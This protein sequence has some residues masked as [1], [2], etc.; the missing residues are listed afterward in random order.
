MSGKKC[1][2]CGSS[3]IEVDPARGDAVCTSCGTVLEDN[4]I[5]AEVEFQETAHGGAAAIGQFVSA[6]TKGGATGF[7]RAFQAGIG[8]ESREIT[9]RKARDGITALC[10]QLRLN[11]QCIDIA[12][13]FFKMALSRHLTIGRPATHTQ[14]ACVYMTCRTEGTAH[15]LID[16][17]DALQICCYQLGRAYF[18]LSRAL[19]INIPPTDP[20]LYILRFASQLQFEDKQHEVSMT[21]LRLVQRMK[22]DSIHSGRRPSGICG[23][24][25]LIAGRLHN[26]SRTPSDMVRIVKV[27][28]STIRKRLIEFGETPSSALTLDE[29]MTVDLEEEQDPPAFRAAR[30]RDKERLQKLMDEED[31]EKELTELQKEIDAQLEKDN[32][33][34][35]KMAT[36]KVITPVPALADE[37]SLEDAEATRFAAEDTLNLLGDI[38][39]DVDPKSEAASKIDKVKFEKGLGPELAVIGLGQPEEKPADKFLKPDPRPPFSADLHA[40][41]E[42]ALSAADEEYISSLIMSEDEARHKTMLWHKLNAGY[43]REQKIKEEVR[44]KE[45]EEGKKRKVRGSYKKKL[46]CNAATAGEAIEKMLAEKKISSKIN[47]D[48]LKS[49]DQPGAP[50]TPAP[51]KDTPAEDVKVATPIEVPA[52]PVPRKRKKKA[53]PATPATPKPAT[54]APATPAPATPAPATPAIPDASEDYEDDAEL[55]PADAGDEMSLAAMLQ[56]GQDDDY[57]D[58]EEY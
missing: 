7:G 17:S 52:S 34:R 35:K 37:C 45:R 49:L 41:E 14:A 22:R 42:L 24:A 13:N 12:C 36:A 27:H 54:P 18:R 53:A 43:L 21:A 6:D 4:I 56:N 47:Y 1:K 50:T 15:L 55:E 16:I 26:F 23:A 29:F 19:C 31:G 57:Y 8:Q 9:L 38:A 28:E 3:E 58:Y 32:S 46:A 33:R 20:C 10:Q 30:K 11:Q 25:L 51:P 44:A 40:A 39:K 2:H 48:I 5:V